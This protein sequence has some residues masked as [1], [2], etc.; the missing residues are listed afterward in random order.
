MDHYEELLEA[1]KPGKQRKKRIT[2]T[3]DE[4]LNKIL[5]ETKKINIS[6]LCNEFLW[7]YI[8]RKRE[9]NEVQ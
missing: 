4:D 6:N 1:I 8:K 5:K 9:E 3:I 2:I 7:Y